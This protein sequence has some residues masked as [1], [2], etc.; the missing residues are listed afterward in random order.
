MGLSLYCAIV[1][2][3]RNSRAIYVDIWSCS[4][5]A[6]ALFVFFCSQNIP[7]GCKILL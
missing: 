4:R 7:P 2:R 3:P 1:V 6:V 5:S